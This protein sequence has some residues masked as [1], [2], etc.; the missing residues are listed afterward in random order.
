MLKLNRTTEYGLIALSHLSQ[1]ALGEAASAREMADLYGLPF[2][3]LAKTLQRL[4]DAGL[5]QSAQG[6]RGGYR[7][8]RELTQVTLSEFLELMEGNTSVVACAE[9]LSD[10]LS[11]CEFHSRCRIQGMMRGLDSR[12]KVFFPEFVYQS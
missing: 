3:I 9:R 2:D 12:L 1:K 8:Q 10:S 11:D 6:A 5:V 7:L 4:K